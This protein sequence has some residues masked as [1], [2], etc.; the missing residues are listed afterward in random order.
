MNK[1]LVCL[2]AMISFLN[3]FK[4]Q[5]EEKNTPLEQTL[6]LAYGAPVKVNISNEICEIIYPEVE[7]EVSSFV[8]VQPTK[9]D[10]QPHYEIKV[11]KIPVPQTVAKCA[12]I[13]DFNGKNQYKATHNSP[14]KM[15]AQVYNLSSFSF[16]KDVDIKTFKEEISVVPELGLISAGD[17]HIADASYTQTDS[18]TGLKSELGNLKDLKVTQNIEEDNGFIKYKTNMLLDSL[19]I[20]LPIFSL[21]I[22]SDRQAADLEYK[23]PEGAS[24]D[25]A[26]I[27]RNFEYLVLSKSKA[28]AKGV[29]LVMKLFDFGISFDL[30][31][32]NYAKIS[33]NGL[34]DTSGNMLISNVVFSGSMID[35]AKQFKSMAMK[36]DIDAISPKSFATLNKIQQDKIESQTQ[37]DQEELAKLL[38]EMLNTAIVKT[39]LDINFANAK[40]TAKFNIQKKNGYLFGD[41]KVSI[42]NLYNIF[43]NMEPCLNNPQAQNIPQCSQNYMFTELSKIVDVK[44]DNPVTEFKFS[45]QG[46]FRNGEKVGEPIELNFQ[47]ILQEQKLKEQQLLEEQK[48]MQ[49][50]RATQQQ[51]DEATPESQ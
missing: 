23:I 27:W 46:V 9:P 2:L 8:L 39:D 10:E 48:K 33:D 35:Q 32:K 31:T 51:T 16:M 14:N 30:D 21:Q 5:A 50:M 17:L 1:I 6:T 4:V 26:N 45:E 13:N 29:N 38:D 47:K 37:P 22:K 3:S 12:K 34:M 25:Y 28:A 20:A 43:P 40:A 44:K 7:M 19:N 24:F 18:T 36:F 49:Q 42:T 41:G 15:V 11:N